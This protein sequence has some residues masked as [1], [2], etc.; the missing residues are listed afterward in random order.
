MAA[1]SEKYQRPG[2]SIFLG[3]LANA[4]IVGHLLLAFA[5]VGV[6]AIGANLIAQH[7]TLLVEKTDTV[8]VRAVEA[9]VVV[10]APILQPQAAAPAPVAKSLDLAELVASIDRFE[11]RHSL[12]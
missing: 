9:P 4:G 12:A 3:K 6:L 5:A 8:V 1:G 10:K 11:Q 2:S 7:G